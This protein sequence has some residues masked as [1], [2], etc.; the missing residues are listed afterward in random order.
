MFSAVAILLFVLSPV[1]VPAAITTV[2]AI[3]GHGRK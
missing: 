1:L 3:G 2:H